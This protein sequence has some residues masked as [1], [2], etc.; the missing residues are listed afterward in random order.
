[1]SDK[2]TEISS[3][4]SSNGVG[5]KILVLVP[6]GAKT[7]FEDEVRHIGYKLYEAV[8]L[9]VYKNDPKTI[10]SHAKEIAD[11]KLL[12]GDRP[13]YVEQIPN[14]YGPYGA[15]WLVVTTNIGRIKLGW[16]KRVINIDWS[17][18]IVKTEAEEL[19]KEEEVTKGYSGEFYVHAWGYEKAKKYIDKI[20][21]ESQKF[22]F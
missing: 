11:L 22:R 3:V 20:H 7:S 9:D 5:V 1:M 6:D 21:E 12:F 19:F 13:I 8:R 16:R 2:W 18:T 10:A 15:P 4:T 17:Q 14:E